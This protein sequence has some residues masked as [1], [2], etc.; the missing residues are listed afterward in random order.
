MTKGQLIIKPIETGN[1]QVL[2]A[3]TSQAGLACFSPNAEASFNYTSFVDWDG[4]GKNIIL[5]CLCKVGEKQM[6]AV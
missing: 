6:T 1:E 5:H 4:T 2:N 3:V